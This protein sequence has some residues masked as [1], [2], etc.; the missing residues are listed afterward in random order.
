MFRLIINVTFVVTNSWFKQSIIQQ[1]TFIV[2]VVLI[3]LCQPYTSE[4]KIFN[5][6]DT[7]IFANLALLNALSLYFYIFFQTY[8]GE[9]LPTSVFVIQYI[10][11]FLPLLYMITYIFYYLSSPC[12]NWI[13]HHI[14]ELRLMCI[15]LFR[16]QKYQPLSEVIRDVSTTDAT[17]NGDEIEALF[18]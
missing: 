14:Q 2:F 3:A 12:H 10:L 17:Q 18:E 5:Y 4:K 1:I 7:L 6:V 13:N 11:L 16:N 9:P 8:T 15:R